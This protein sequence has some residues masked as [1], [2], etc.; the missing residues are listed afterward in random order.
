MKKQ[1]RALFILKKLDE[2]YPRPKPPLKHLDPY[3]LLVAVVLS[4]R[5]TDAK[6]NEITKE[7]FKLASTPQ[8]MIKLSEEQ[9]R[10]IIRPCGLSPAKA[11]A[12]LG[13]SKILIEKHGGKVPADFAALEELPGVGHKTASVVMVQAFE[14]PAFPIDT[15]IYRLARRW[16]LTKGKSVKQVEKDLKEVFPRPNWGKVHLQM[17]YYGKEHCS[18]RRCR[19]IECLIC[20][21][22]VKK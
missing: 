3:T 8:E 22:L 21:E 13:L 19:G 14:V 12:I 7:L 20:K 16:K 18:A 2:M 6:V 17:I 4:A 9:I 5:S 15:H 10:S 1:E 11:K